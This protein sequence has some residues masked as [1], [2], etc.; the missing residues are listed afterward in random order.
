[1]TLENLKSIYQRFTCE[2]IKFSFKKR[3]F[4]LLFNSFFKDDLRNTDN[5][6]IKNYKSSG[7]GSS[8]SGSS[9]SGSSGLGSSESGSS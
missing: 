5:W 6:G 4:P 9:G 2:K 3:K 8:G 1:M 7:S